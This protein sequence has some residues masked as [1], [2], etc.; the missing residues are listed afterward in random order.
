[1][2]TRKRREILRC[3]ILL[4]GAA[5]AANTHVAQAQTVRFDISAPSIGEALMELAQ[6]SGLQIA[7]PTEGLEGPAPHI[8]GRLTPR[9]ALE[10]LLADSGFS[11]GFANAKTVTIRIDERAIDKTRPRVGDPS[12]SARAKRPARDPKGGHPNGDDGASAE[13]R[14]GTNAGKGRDDA[15]VTVTAHPTTKAPGSP[16]L[17]VYGRDQLDDSG[18]ATT[19]EFLKTIAVNFTGAGDAHA[20]SVGRPA[21]RSGYSLGLWGLDPEQTLVLVDGQRMAPA[22]IGSPV[23]DLS[24]IPLAAIERVEVMTDG[25]STTYGSDA[26]AGVVNIVLRNQHGGAE[27]QLRRGI[28]TQGGGG[29][30][31]V[32][33]TFGLDWNG[34]VGLLAFDYGDRRTIRREQRASLGSGEA[35]DAS[36]MGNLLPASSRTSA[37]LSLTQ[38]LMGGAEV[39]ANFLLAEKS[40]DP[41][42]VGMASSGYATGHAQSS[43]GAVSF[44]KK[45]GR[46]WRIVAAASYHHDR[47]RLFLG[48]SRN[49][50]GPSSLWNAADY[51]AS[52]LDIKADRV[53]SDEAA[54]QTKWTLGAQHRSEGFAEGAWPS[55]TG[56]GKR[57]RR[58]INSFFTELAIPFSLSEDASIVNTIEVIVGLR[59]EEYSDQASSIHPKVGIEWA[60]ASSWVLRGGFATSFRAAALA[61]SGEELGGC[62]RPETAAAY[63][64]GFSFQPE[65]MPG[66]D[67]TATYFNIRFHDRLYMSPRL[68][69]PSLFFAQP[70]APLA[71]SS[72]YNLAL[73]RTESAS[74]S[75]RNRLPLGSGTWDTW[76]DASK[77]LSS[78]AQITESTAAVRMT[79]MI[80][81]PSPLQ[82]RGGV[83]WANGGFS[84]TLSVRHIGSYR[85]TLPDDAR[86]IGS[87]TTADLAIHLSTDDSA[88]EG[89][90]N[91]RLSFGVE[92][93]LDKRPPTLHSRSGEDEL[94]PYD[95]WNASVRGRF[96]SVLLGKSW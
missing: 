45:L 89:L 91:L 58:S 75:A 95:P 41:D 18:A 68:V 48:P 5:L 14:S 47:T 55:D 81:S 67:V 87:W 15:D 63:T 44:S 72:A 37:L 53:S 20:A 9:A 76:F 22:D 17:R 90:E 78:R 92:N 16:F 69:T 8:N 25:A 4:A 31:G 59:W 51:A 96:I 65:W 21:T 84:A 33:Q 38:G 35:S 46:G 66:L 61:D 74:V 73:S 52:S 54:L 77:I 24:S 94:L 40:D 13:L 26:V 6:Q 64:F 57:V 85:W 43:A 27:I 11:Y 34:G 28:A 93:L 19:A 82:A 56:G 1:M 79:G 39:R 60:P 7:F 71:P 88:P 83:D 80:Y 12:Q 36:A 42:V 29:E 70:Q 10:R 86:Q 50:R 2:Q 49:D 30:I 62:P 3:G 23:V 32:A